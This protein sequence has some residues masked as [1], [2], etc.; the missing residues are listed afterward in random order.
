[1]TSRDS[2]GT[3]NYSGTDTD[4]EDDSK[5]KKCPV[6]GDLKDHHD[7]GE[8]PHLRTTG[9]ICQPRDTGGH[10]VIGTNPKDRRVLYQ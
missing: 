4:G 6:G 7:N 3:D 2:R 10:F 9:T 1:M 5:D 8:S